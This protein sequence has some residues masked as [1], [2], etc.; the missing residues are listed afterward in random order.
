MLIKTHLVIVA[1]F[2]ILLIPFVNNPFLFSVI[3]FFATILPDIDSKFSSIGKPKIN[4]ILQFF[5][6]HRG[7]FHSL[8]FCFVV[9]LFLSFFIP[10]LAFAFFLGYSVHLFSDS[11]TKDGI[12]VFWPLKK[13]SKG[14]LVTG[15]IFEKGLFFGFIAVDLIL[16]WVYLF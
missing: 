8:T 5:S 12:P 7:M 4:R 15:G 6:K 14:F 10:V 9:S 1:L 11:F 3:A 2:I 13:H 16:V